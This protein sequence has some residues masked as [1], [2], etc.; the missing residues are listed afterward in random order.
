M[1][2]L[3]GLELGTASAADR[4]HLS[5]NVQHVGPLIPSTGRFGIPAL[6]AAVLRVEHKVPRDAQ[7]QLFAVCEPAA[8]RL[9]IRA[10]A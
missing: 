10:R 7:G 2:T 9:P 1:R 3:P 5:M 6:I 8:R 4:S